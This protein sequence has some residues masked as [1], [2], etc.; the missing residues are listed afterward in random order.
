MVSKEWAAVRKEWLQG[1]RE[2]AFVIAA[3]AV[4]IAL[5]W[6]ADN[7]GS[8]T[9]CAGEPNQPG[10]VECVEPGSRLHLESGV[11]VRTQH[12]WPTRV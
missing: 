9:G 7:H 11:Q 12:R 4:V 8:P 2:L 1:V 6:L 10:V 3:S 5:L